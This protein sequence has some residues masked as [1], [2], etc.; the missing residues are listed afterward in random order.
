MSIGLIL[1]LGLIVYLFRDRI[2]AFFGVER[3]AKAELASKKA[4]DGVLNGA[5]TMA[6]ELQKATALS[7]ELQAE[8]D[9][10]VKASA[11]KKK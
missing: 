9:A 2:K 3:A 5:L 10:L 1:F 4:A 8:V 11:S 7:P 6:D